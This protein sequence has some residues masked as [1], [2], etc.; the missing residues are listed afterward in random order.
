MRAGNAVADWFSGGD[1]QGGTGPG[2]AARSAA[3]QAGGGSQSVNGQ[4]SVK[5][6]NAP[7]GMRVEKVQSDGGVAVDADVGHNMAAVQ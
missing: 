5:F 6:E 2:V 3:M 1:K 4:V 7:A